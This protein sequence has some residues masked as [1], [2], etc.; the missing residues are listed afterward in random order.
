MVALCDL[1]RNLFPLN[2]FPLF[3]IVCL[4]GWTPVQ[5]VTGEI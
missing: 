3:S 4:E 1:A 2:Y 5:P